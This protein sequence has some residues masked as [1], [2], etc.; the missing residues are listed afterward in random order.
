MLFCGGFWVFC[1]L[2][3]FFSSWIFL[4]FLLNLIYWGIFLL[5]LIF[6]LFVSW[7]F[8][9]SRLYKLPFEFLTSIST[10]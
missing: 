4:D 7:F 5:L 3:F 1:V 10:H 2:F 8:L 6:G 9:V